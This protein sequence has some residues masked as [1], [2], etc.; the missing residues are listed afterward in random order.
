MT[1]V[2]AFIVWR[3]WYGMQDKILYNQTTFILQFPVW[4]GYAI[5]LPWALLFVVVSAFTIYRSLKQAIMPS[6]YS[7]QL[8]RY[9]PT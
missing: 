2:A 9:R 3:L 1:L 5:C 7:L 6:R 8:Y 4:W